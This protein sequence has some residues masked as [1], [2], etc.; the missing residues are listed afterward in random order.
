M[1][2][3]LYFS[4]SS[5]TVDMMTMAMACCCFSSDT[6]TPALLVEAAF[7]PSGLSIPE[8]TSQHLLPPP[9]PTVSLLEIPVDH[10]VGEALPADPDALQHSV[11]GQLV[12]HQGWTEQHITSPHHITKSH[13]NIISYHHI[14][15]QSLRKTLTGVDDSCS[16][17]GVGHDAPVVGQVTE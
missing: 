8:Q 11:T 6:F 13:Q 10:P 9:S 4:F 14:S 3:S 2:P 16:L 15:P 17:V 7:T 1:W 5:P 12:H